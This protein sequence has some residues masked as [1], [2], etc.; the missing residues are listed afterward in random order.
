MHLRLFFVDNKTQLVLRM[1]S[2]SSIPDWVLEATDCKLFEVSSKK[3]QTI[4]KRVCILI[5][6]ISSSFVN[7]LIMNKGYLC[8]QPSTRNRS[9]GH[10]NI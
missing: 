10:G 3:K 7:T 4:V 9:T 2:G 1:F 8:F 5:H 6:Y